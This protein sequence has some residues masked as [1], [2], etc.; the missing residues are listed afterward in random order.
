MKLKEIIK[1][2]KFHCEYE[3]NLSTKT[4]QAYKIDL[5]QFLNFK[6]YKNIDI[7]NFDKY[8]LKDY[9]QN[10]YI[11]EFKAKTIKRKIAV[12]KA[13]FSYLEFEEIILVSPFRKMRV[14][15]KEPKNLPKTIQLRE[16][17]KVL[18]YLY[19]QKE[20]FEDKNIYSYKAL[21]R[22]IGIIEI[23]FTTGIRVSEVCN[24]KRE[25]INLQTGIITIQGKG[26]KERVIQI[27][28]SEVK[29]TLKEY[30]NLF[31]NQLKENEY[32][33]INRLGNQI[34]EQSVRLMIKKYQK[35]SGVQKHITPHMFRHSF[36]T[37]LLEEGVD[38][39]YIQHMLGHS[40]ISTT[41]IYTQV[42]LKQQK[43]I[44]N[45]KHP[46]RTFNFA[47]E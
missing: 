22:D 30:I 35:E 9:I 14:A 16:I 45:N 27:C 40:S 34:S 24:I 28:D 7:N 18:K 29:K 3:K 44:L 1:D 15:I 32:F 23:L 47:S 13:L 26:N 12:L 19:R 31:A 42:N 37:L 17:K 8:K 5:E 36:A 43:K 11:Q 4:L 2:F 10:L 39:R 20:Q 46:R 21:V 33:L 6:D 38:I 25:N 41:Q